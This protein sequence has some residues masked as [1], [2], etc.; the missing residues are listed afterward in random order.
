MSVHSHDPPQLN[1][2]VKC[3]QKPVKFPLFL[4]LD[5]YNMRDVRF[6]VYLICGGKWNPDSFYVN[7]ECVPCGYVT[8]LSWFFVHSAQYSLLRWLTI[9]LRNK[10]FWYYAI[11]SIPL[12]NPSNPSHH[13]FLQKKAQQKVSCIPPKY[14]FFL[15]AFLSV[16][17][18]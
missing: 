8:S 11:C 1:L 16:V 17:E 14:P 15:S 9:F 7:S 18:W 10:E 4:I 3:I 13:P 5:T 12:S 2:L 6:W